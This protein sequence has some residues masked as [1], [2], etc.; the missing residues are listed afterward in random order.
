[1]RENKI[2][3]LLQAGKPTLSTRIQSVWPSI[4]EVIGH[5]G[6]FD[7]VEFLDRKSVV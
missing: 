1:M 6:L 7:Y 4:V 3:T 5:T 2:R